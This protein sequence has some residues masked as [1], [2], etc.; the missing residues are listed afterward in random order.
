[1]ASSWRLRCQFYE[2]AEYVF[3][4]WRVDAIARKSADT[5]AGDS[6]HCYDC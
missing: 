1:M 5:T 4:R 2:F 6:C 3:A